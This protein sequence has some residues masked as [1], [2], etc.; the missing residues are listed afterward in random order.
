MGRRRSRPRNPT[1]GDDDVGV[2]GWRRPRRCRRH[3]CRSRRRRRHPRSRPLRLCPRRRCRHRWRHQVRPARHGPG[4]VPGDRGDAADRP[5]GRPGRRRCRRRR[6]PRSRRH[7]RCRRPGLAGVRRRA[8]CTLDGQRGSLGSPASAGT[9]VHPPRRPPPTPSPRPPRRERVCCPTGRARGPRRRGPPWNGR[10]GCARRVR[11]GRRAPVCWSSRA[12]SP[13]NGPSAG[14]AGPR[15]ATSL[16]EALRMGHRLSRIL[17]KPPGASFATRPR[18]GFA[19]GPG[20]FSRT[21][22][23]LAPSGSFRT[24]S[25]PVV[26]DGWT[27]GARIAVRGGRACRSLHSGVRRRS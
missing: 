7:P 2:D 18:E 15:A 24:H 25:A 27:V 16:L 14:Q 1:C 11:P 5:G 3:R 9:R 8:A 4:H 6:H 17:L 23:G 13:A 21:C 26:N 10:C 20:H 19:M 12:L 22:D